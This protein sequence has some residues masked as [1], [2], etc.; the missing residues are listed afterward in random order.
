MTTGRDGVG[1]LLGERLELGLDVLVGAVGL[2]PEGSGER[3]AGR[4]AA[5]VGAVAARPNAVMSATRVVAS[6]PE[7]AISSRCAAPATSTSAKPWP[8]SW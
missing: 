7:S 1:M 2:R 3:A 6:R 4:G 8:R 5:R